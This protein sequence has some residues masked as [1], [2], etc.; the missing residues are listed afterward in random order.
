MLHSDPF[1]AYDLAR[2]RQQ[3]LLAE[4]ERDRLAH[5]VARADLS[6][7]DAERSS[8]AHLPLAAVWRLL[9]RAAATTPSARLTIGTGQ[10]PSYPISE[11][12]QR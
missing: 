1:V 3:A 8:F 4:A 6:S 12:S 11:L 9:G 10:L 7:R 5:A 2:Q